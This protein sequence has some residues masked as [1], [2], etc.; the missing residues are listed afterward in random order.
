MTS[1][2][3]IVNPIAVRQRKDACALAADQLLRWKF[4]LINIIGNPVADALGFNQS[5]AG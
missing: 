2:S 4:G 3:K 1:E 5:A